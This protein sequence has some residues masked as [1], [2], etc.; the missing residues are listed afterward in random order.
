MTQLIVIG[1]RHYDKG[2]CTSE[3][4]HKILEKID[5]EVIFEEIPPSLHGVYHIER[6]KENLETNAIN[7][8]LEKHDLR[9][10]PVDSDLMPPD[11]FFEEFKKMHQAIE[12]ISHTYCHLTDTNAAHT[13][14][15]G[16]RYLNSELHDDLHEKLRISIDEG[17]K[18]LNNQNFFDFQSRWLKIIDLR[19]ETMMNGIY[20]HLQE[21]GFARAVFLI[22]SSHRR[23]IMQKAVEREKINRN[24]IDWNLKNYAGIL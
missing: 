1:T 15:H 2:I 20:N 24:K 21:P 16:F 22:G 18:H 12:K 10:I 8:Y 23:S 9:L 7:A 4:L 11:S 13:A 19:E 17:L 5:P 3:E 14:I 6:S